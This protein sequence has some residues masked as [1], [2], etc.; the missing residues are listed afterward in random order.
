MSDERQER[1]DFWDDSGLTCGMSKGKT[2]RTRKRGDVSDERQE[3]GDFWDDGGLASGMS[4]GK[5]RGLRGRKGKTC[6]MSG[7]KGETSGM[8]VG[9]QV[10]AGKWDEQREDLWAERQ[11]REDV[12]DEGQERARLPFAQLLG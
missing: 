6:G 12:W 4:K 10:W 5:T 2:C 3:R 11:G 8:T 1:G 7:R 9:W